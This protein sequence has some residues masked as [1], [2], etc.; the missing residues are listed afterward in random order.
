MVATIVNTEMAQAWN[1]AEG[2]DWARDW[3][4]Y[5]LAVRRHHLRLLQAAAPQPDERALDVGCGNGEV[6]RDLARRG[7][8]V[9][10]I[11]L[12]HQMLARARELGPDV[13]HI[14]GDAQVHPFPDHA[15][16]LVVSRFGTMFFADRVAAFRNLARATRPGGRL[17]LVAWQGLDHNEWL[18]ELR[19]ALAAGRDLPVPPPGAAGPFSQADPEAACAELSA[20]GWSG[21]TATPLREDFWAGRDAED[22]YAFLVSTGPSRGL[23]EPLTP[24]EAD[25]ARAALRDACARHESER[26][27]VFGSAVWLFT[28]TSGG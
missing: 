25:A 15:F 11:D 3:E 22:A 26:G 17:A 8:R 10:G 19:G 21:V 24:T 28:G 23:L 4:R 6:A 13:E 18:Q 20:A 14:E 1:G 7:L 16:D 12:S 2:D 27:V 9:T 5:D